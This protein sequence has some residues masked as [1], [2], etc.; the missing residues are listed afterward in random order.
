MFSF[1]EDTV[2]KWQDN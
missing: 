2:S 1:S